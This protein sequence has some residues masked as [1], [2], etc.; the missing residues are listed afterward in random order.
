[1]LGNIC[2]IIVL[3]WT[4]G[5]VITRW[6]PYSSNK[7][8]KII[9]SYSVRKYVL[10]YRTNLN[11]WHSNYIIIGIVAN[12]NIIIVMGGATMILLLHRA[13]MTLN[14]VK[15][16]WSHLK[17]LFVWHPHHDGLHCVTFIVLISWVIQHY[18]ILSLI[19]WC[20][21]LFWFMKKVSLLR[22][23]V[24]VIH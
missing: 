4:Y 17:I 2:N 5:T 24:L 13:A 20:G 12:N 8:I 6:L 14:N 16:R 19:P 3:T 11:L 18:N 1:V 10:Y 7:C 15:C 21:Y 9:T 23:L 22:R